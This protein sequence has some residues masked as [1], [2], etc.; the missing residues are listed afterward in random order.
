MGQLRQNPTDALRAVEAGETYRITRHSR[1]I[2]RIVPPTPGLELIPP[3][4]LG[5]T[6]LVGVAPHQLISAA[7]IDELLDDE[8]GTW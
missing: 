2:A 3:T 1:V 6:Q 4:R 8:R 7:S 5:G